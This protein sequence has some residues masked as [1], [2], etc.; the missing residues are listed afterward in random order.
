MASEANPAP[1]QFIWDNLTKQF[2]SS[3]NWLILPTYG[4]VILLQTTLNQ[5]VISSSCCHR[6]NSEGRVTTP[7]TTCSLSAEEK[8][9]PGALGRWEILHQAPEGFANTNTT[10]M[11]A[12]EITGL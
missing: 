7:M 11:E 6:G 4:Y 2:L 5:A 10:A 3:S 9:Q 8:L 1:R 12:I